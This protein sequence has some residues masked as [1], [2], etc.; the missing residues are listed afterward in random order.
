MDVADGR[1]TP[2]L[3][4]GTLP[5]SGAV[6]S[7]DR[8]PDRRGSPGFSWRR[9]LS[10]SWPLLLAPLIVWLGLPLCPSRSLF[11]VPCPGCGLTRAT[12]AMLVL[13]WPRMVAMHPLAPI[14][15]PVVVWWIASAALTSAG[16][17][18]ARSWDPGRIIPRRGWFALGAA[19]VGLFALRAMGLLG[20]L[21]DPID[22]AGGLIGRAALAVWSL[23][24]T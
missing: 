20:G 2:T 1:K 22:P 24:S 8:S 21:P 3:A 14:V 5:A 16:L 19:L 10:T 12:L 13:D 7:A 11:G 18:S 15:T 4:T 17:E 9:L 6:P 23:V